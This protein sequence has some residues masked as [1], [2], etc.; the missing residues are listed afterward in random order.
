M[1]IGAVSV[2]DDIFGQGLNPFIVGIHCSGSE[3]RLLDC[4]RSRLIDDHPDISYSYG[5]VGIICQGVP[6]SIVSECT[7]GDVRLAYG[8]R[9]AEGRVEICVD[10]RWSAPCWPYWNFRTTQLICKQLGFPYEGKEL[11]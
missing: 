2:E 5:H 4:P 11:C 9:K 1:P 7:Q 3:S 8:K 6:K 10:G